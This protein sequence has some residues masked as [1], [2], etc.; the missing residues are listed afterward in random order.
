MDPSVAAVLSNSRSC[1][2]CETAKAA[3]LLAAGRLVAAEA[4][5][6]GAATAVDTGGVP[7]GGGGWLVPVAVAAPMW[8]WTRLL[9]LLLLR[10]LLP[11]LPLLELLVPLDPVW[12]LLLLALLAP[13]FGLARPARL[14]T[15]GAA[16]AA[17]AVVVADACA[18]APPA[19]AACGWVWRVARG[20]VAAAVPPAG[21]GASCTTSPGNKATPCRGGSVGGEG[22]AVRGQA[23]DGAVGGVCHLE[24]AGVQGGGGRGERPGT[25]LE[26]VRRGSG[27]R[28]AWRASDLKHGCQAL[29]F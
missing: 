21:A 27:C 12:V 13:P 28:A 5:A 8:G 19:V 14:V 3:A 10:L 9:A 22:R 24:E 4:P 20:L 17:A 25:A 26:W 15:P 11:L 2:D 1:S 23:T 16:V 29:D 6:A 18:D 7:G